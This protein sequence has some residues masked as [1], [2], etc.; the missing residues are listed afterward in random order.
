MLTLE[1]SRGRTLY[2]FLDKLDTSVVVSH[3]LGLL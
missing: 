3:I 1:E 2:H